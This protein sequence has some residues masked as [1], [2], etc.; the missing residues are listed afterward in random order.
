MHLHKTWFIVILYY[1]WI[2]LEA[3]ELRCSFTDACCR[4]SLLLRNT[5]W[6]CSQH[7]QSALNIAAL[8]DTKSDRVN[9]M[10]V[11]KAITWFTVSSLNNDQ[12]SF[13][14]DLYN[15]LPCKAVCYT[16]SYSG[17]WCNAVRWFIGAWM[18]HNTCRRLRLTICASQRVRGLRWMTAT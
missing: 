3:C 18:R 12:L 9:M 13:H 1:L 16:G 4:I 7:K 10:L 17:L 14:L 15:T 2:S 5:C 11:Q 6:I 8:P